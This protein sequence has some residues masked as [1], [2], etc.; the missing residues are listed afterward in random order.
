MTREQAHA[1]LTKYLH[2]KNLLKHSYA[3]EAV[4]KAVYRSLH[5]DGT[6]EEE[7]KWGITGLLHDIDYEL[8][9]TSDQLHK[10]GLLFFE[11]EPDT[12]PEDIA[13]AI[14]SHNFENTKVTPENTMDWAIVCVD[15]LTGLIVAATLIHPDKKLASITPDFVLKRFSEKAFARGAKRENILLSQEKLG[16]SLEDFVTLALS[17]MQEI[18]TDLGL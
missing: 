8:A 4:M 3:A 18:H 2:N 9:Q 11:K 5:A 1:L 14:K 7:D 16:I 10:H 13:H 12:L 17:A 15:Q 6:K